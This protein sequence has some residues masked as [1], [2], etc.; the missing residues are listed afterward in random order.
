MACQMLSEVANSGPQIWFVEMIV[1]FEFGGF[2]LLLL[3][4]FF[5]KGLLFCFAFWLM[6]DS[7]NQDIS[8]KNLDFQFFLKTWKTW[9]S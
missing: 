7:E 9:L 2:L 1:W 8:R 5:W 4:G 6:E 3:F